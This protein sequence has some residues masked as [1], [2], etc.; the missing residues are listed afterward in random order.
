M[1]QAETRLFVLK[2]LEVQERLNS[3]V[4]FDYIRQYR[5]LH[6]APAKEVR[7]APAEATQ[8]QPQPKDHGLQRD[9]VFAPAPGPQ[10]RWHHHRITGR[11]NV[12]TINLKFNAQRPR[13]RGNYRR[14][15]REEHQF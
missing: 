12:S 5:L 4:H 7:V 15:G 1:Q 2:A 14:L 8:A 3:Q 10:V 6:Q 11:T 9:Q 13:Q